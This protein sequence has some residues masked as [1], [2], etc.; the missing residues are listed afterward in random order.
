MIIQII[1]RISVVSLKQLIQTIYD[2][3]TPDRNIRKF[4]APPIFPSGKTEQ[5]D[6]IQASPNVVERKLDL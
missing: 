6:T 2:E 1:G 3:L 4:P 5:Y